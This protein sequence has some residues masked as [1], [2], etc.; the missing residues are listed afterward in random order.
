MLVSAGNLAAGNL[1]LIETALTS[2][3]IASGAN[4][5]V[6]LDRH[7]WRNTASAN[8]IAANVMDG[9]V[10][11]VNGLEV[12]GSLPNQ[13]LSTSSTTVAAG[14]YPATDLAALQPGLVSA[15]VLSGSNIFGVLGASTVL[16]TA[17]ANAIAG[18]LLAGANAFV[19]GQLVTGTMA[20]RTLSADSSSQPAGYYGATDLATVEMD[21][22]GASIA[23]GVNILGV[24]GTNP[25]INTIGANAVA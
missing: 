1:Q 19:G 3:N 2:A 17:L 25:G 11:W 12:T 16:D 18:N 14:A 7:R 24:V 21:L 4:I 22:T 10:V 6:S 15:N 5:L 23:T 20:T 8:A 9:W 13:T